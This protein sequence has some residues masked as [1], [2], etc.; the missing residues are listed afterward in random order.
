MRERLFHQYA[1]N[2]C[3]SGIFGRL[4]GGSCRKMDIERT[5]EASASV[6]PSIVHV[7]Q[8]SKP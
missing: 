4:R 3:K 6:I 1:V 2:M 7:W 8:I 5:F